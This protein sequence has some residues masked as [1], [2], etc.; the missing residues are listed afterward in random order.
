MKLEKRGKCGM[1]NGEMS[2]SVFFTSVSHA[3]LDL[4]VI[5]ADGLLFLLKHFLWIMFYQD[6]NNY[7]TIFSLCNAQMNW[8]EFWTKST[9]N[10]HIILLPS[11]TYNE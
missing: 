10:F 3:K 4:I 8:Y 7:Y 2:F 1:N 6:N 9:F 11:F 5:L